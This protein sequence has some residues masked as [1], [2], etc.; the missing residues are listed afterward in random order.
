M[1]SFQI[2]K[3]STRSTRA[4]AR[5]M[6]LSERVDPN[7]IPSASASGGDVAGPALSNKF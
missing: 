4:Q 6:S 2:L 3:P 5:R 1:C 7:L